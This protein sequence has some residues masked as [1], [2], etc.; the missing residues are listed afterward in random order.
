MMNYCDLY[1]AIRRDAGDAGYVVR[2]WAF[3]LLTQISEG[4]R[5][6][7]GVRH[8]LGFICLPVEREADRGVCVHLWCDRMINAQPTTSVIHSHSW[9]LLSYVLFGQISNQVVAAADA[10]ERPEYRVFEVRSHGDVD[11]IRATA[12]L[13]RAEP[14][15]VELANAGSSYRLPAARFH[16]TTI[17]DAQDT[18]TVAL[19][20]SRPGAFDLTLGPIGTSTHQV[21]RQRCDA[22]ETALAARIVADRLATAYTAPSGGLGG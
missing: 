13:V 14:A 1:E 3:D 6:L 12:R 22:E 5:R 19:G 16:V 21:R 8:P 2:G 17:P 18:A 15:A 11:E 20:V 4:R 7:H 10:P 9:D